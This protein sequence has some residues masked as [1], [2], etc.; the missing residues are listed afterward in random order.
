MMR[1]L[2]Y[3]QTGEQ[4]WQ[5][6]WGCKEPDMFTEQGRNAQFDKDAV[7]KGECIA[8]VRRVDRGQISQSLVDHH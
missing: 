6:P 1:S 3:V 2:E 5:K 4:Q 8:E 7:S